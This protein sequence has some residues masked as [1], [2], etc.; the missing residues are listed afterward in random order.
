MGPL[1]KKEDVAV[2]TLKNSS[3]QHPA[4]GQHNPRGASTGAIFF[5]NIK[6]EKSKRIHV[7]KYKK[8]TFP[9]GHFLVQAPLEFQ[10]L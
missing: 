6:K 9:N 3:T 1:R 8:M 10:M 4:D 7:P 5:Q 2:A